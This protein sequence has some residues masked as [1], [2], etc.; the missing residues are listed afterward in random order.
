MNQWQDNALVIIYNPI[1]EAIRINLC[2]KE[3]YIKEYQII[4]RCTILVCFSVTNFVGSPT[5]RP[6]GSD[7]LTHS[8]YENTRKWAKY[9]I[10]L[11]FCVIQKVMQR[12]WKAMTTEEATNFFAGY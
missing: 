2:S 4:S 5:I 6:Q 9:N 1:Q 7:S 12:R 11:L 10:G 8:S 3:P